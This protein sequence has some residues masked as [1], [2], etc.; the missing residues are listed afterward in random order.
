MVLHLPQRQGILFLAA[1][2]VTGAPIVFRSSVIN[3]YGDHVTSC[4]AWNSSGLI[5]KLAFALMY[6]FHLL[7]L[8][9]GRS[10]FY[11]TC[12]FS[13]LHIGA[14]S[15]G[16]LNQLENIWGHQ[17]PDGENDTNEIILVPASINMTVTSLHVV[18]I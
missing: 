2:N 15:L 6:V 1:M 14:L 16:G 11:F 7:G 4:E 8:D 13:L 3:K 17:P 18:R 10:W 9:W 12:A 5:M